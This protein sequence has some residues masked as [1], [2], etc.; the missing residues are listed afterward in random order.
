MCVSV[1]TLR[2]PL[3]KAEIDAETLHFL[4]PFEYTNGHVNIA[5]G[6]G[7]HTVPRDSQRHAEIPLY[8]KRLATLVKFSRWNQFRDVIEV[9][10]G[11]G[12]LASREPI[13]TSKHLI[14]MLIEISTRSSV[15]LNGLKCGVV[16]HVGRVNNIQS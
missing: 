4:L 5:A 9:G 13:Y 3:H 10:Y 8:S 12:C 14:V 1:P 6:S 15:F 2:N 16:V 7:R 11:E